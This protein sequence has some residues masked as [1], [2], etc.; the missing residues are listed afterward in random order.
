MT[1]RTWRSCWRRLGS[2]AW[3]GEIGA[4]EPFGRLRT[5]PSTLR[6]GSGQAR[7]LVRLLALGVGSKEKSPWRVFQGLCQF[8]VVR[9]LQYS[10]QERTAASA[11]SE[12]RTRAISKNTAGSR[13]GM[14]SVRV[15]RSFLGIG[16]LCHGLGRV[17][18]IECRRAKGHGLPAR[19]FSFNTRLTPCSGCS[20]LSIDPRTATGD[21]LK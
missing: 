11:I 16:G 5:G 19:Q 6:H 10:A 21:R 4:R 15:R 9:V 14:G 1:T 7:S 17:A 13:C 18:S 20:I 3:G 2:R 8:N 12:R